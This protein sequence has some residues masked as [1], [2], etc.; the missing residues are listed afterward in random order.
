M[1]CF[2]MHHCLHHTQ[3]R[4]KEMKITSDGCMFFVMKIIL[5]LAFFVVVYECFFIARHEWREFR[6]PQTVERAQ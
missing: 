6:K 3:E 5:I 2:K 4:P 1:L